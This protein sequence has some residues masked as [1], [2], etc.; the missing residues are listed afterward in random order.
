MEQDKYLKQIR[1]DVARQPGTLLFDPETFR[2][3][4]DELTLVRHALSQA[5]LLE[6]AKVASKVRR[7]LS[8]EVAGRA[9][10]DQNQDDQQ[11]ADLVDHYV[12]GGSLSVKLET[13]DFLEEANP[14][15]PS[16]KRRKLNELSA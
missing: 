7:A 11:E 4:S 1:K 10:E 6:Y 8:A 3:M 2:D 15:Q 9:E 12:A 16:L 5:Q 14:V 13:E